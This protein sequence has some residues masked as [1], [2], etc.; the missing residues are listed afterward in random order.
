MSHLPADM[1]PLSV[2]G[3][4]ALAGY[5]DRIKSA[6][7]YSTVK[8]TCWLPLSPALRCQK[9][10]STGSPSD[11]VFVTVCQERLK[12]HQVRRYSCLLPVLRWLCNNRFNLIVRVK[13]PV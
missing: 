8:S 5:S 9:E 2:L 13:N 4:A 1:A 7:L 11:R 12:D 6:F 10:L 3:R